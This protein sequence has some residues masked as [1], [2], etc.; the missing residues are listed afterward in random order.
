[1]LHEAG[2]AAYDKY[3]DGSLPYI[4]RE[5]SHTMFTEAIAMLMGRLSTDV[6]WLVNYA[7]AP[8][9]ETLALEPQLSQQISAQLLILSRWVL[10]MSHFE[11]SLYH[12]P[13]QKLNQL[14]WDLVER[15]QGVPRPDGRDAP[16]WAAKIHFSIAPVYY[17]NYLMGELIASQIRH[18]IDAQVLSGSP[19]ANRH[20]VTDPAVGHY[21][22]NE[23]FRLGARFDWQSTLEKTTGE[24]LNP[25]YFV[26][27]ASNRS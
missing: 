14:W 18:Y 16:D 27:Q 8:A 19:D 6:D 5:P 15:F 26:Q 10:V 20:F 24:R 9:N 22:Q 11:R 4:L 2:H 23:L 7:K 17:H 12:D 13:R 25:R 3:L 1:M 21:L